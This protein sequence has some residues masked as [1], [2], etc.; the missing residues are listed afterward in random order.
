VSIA[1]SGSG[2][3]NAFAIQSLG[4]GLQ[5]L[6]VRGHI[7]NPAN[8]PCF[9]GIDSQFF[10]RG[11]VHRNS[12]IAVAATTSVLPSQD[13]TL[14]ATMGLLGKFLHIKAVHHTVNRHQHMRLFVIGINALADCDEPN[15]GEV[16]PLKDAQRILRIS[17]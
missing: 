9:A 4:N 2:R 17:G 12:I 11:S 15:A 6:P 8:D 16:Q 3:S 13:A 1:G 14:H 7:E 10:C 5:G